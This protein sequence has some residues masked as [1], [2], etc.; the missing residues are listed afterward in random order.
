MQISIQTSQQVMT[1]SKSI[2]TGTTPVG[3]VP[4]AY[5]GPVEATLLLPR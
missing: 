2:L 1:V 4:V 3:K 5:L